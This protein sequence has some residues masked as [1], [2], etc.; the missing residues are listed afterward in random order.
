MPEVRAAVE[1]DARGA[2]DP[3]PH[4]SPSDTDGRLRSLADAIELPS[5]VKSATAPEGARD[6]VFS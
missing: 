2:S 3:Q 5:A 1:A 4:R 6:T